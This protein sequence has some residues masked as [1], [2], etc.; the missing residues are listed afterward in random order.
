MLERAVD[1][2]VPRARRQAAG[3]RE[4]E[5]RAWPPPRAPWVMGQSWERLLFAHWRV[6][7][8]ALRA[9]VPAP[10][11]VQAFDGSGWLGV[12]PFA[13]R[14]LRA[15]GMPPVAPVAGFPELNVRTYVTLGD[16][17]GI[18]FFSLDA[19]SRLGVEAA[20]RLYRLP[21]LR[22]RMRI[23]ER[24]GWVRYVSERDD[25]RGAP[26]A[27]RARYRPAGPPSPPAPGTLEHFLTERY[28]LYTIAAGRLLRGEIH[29]PPWPLCSAEAEL[30]VNTMAA[31]LGIELA[32]APL[33]HFADRQDVLIWPL[34][35]ARGR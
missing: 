15:R 26:A 23:D 20:R 18:W 9:R 7:A 11:E 8:E 10:L 12:T 35:P 29:H 2:L 3:L 31:P 30:E 16:R 19:G 33:V 28:V 4:Q 6:A 24:D 1:A 27:F 17:P 14:G 32:G 13:V 22:A 5:H 21:Y 25:S 34:L